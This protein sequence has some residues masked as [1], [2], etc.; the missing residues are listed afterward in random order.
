MILIF[1]FHFIECVNGMVVSLMTIDNNSL[2][3]YYKV[4]EAS[5]LILYVYVNVHC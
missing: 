1:V 4:R 3:Q 5:L 2:R